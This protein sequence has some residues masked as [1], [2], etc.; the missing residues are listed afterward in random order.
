MI[1]LETTALINKAI[2]RT[3]LGRGE[4]RQLGLMLQDALKLSEY[5]SKMIKEMRAEI[6]K[7]KL[8]RLKVMKGENNAS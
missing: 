2:G 4:Q 1:T 6:L 8:V 3:N 5:Q 7:L